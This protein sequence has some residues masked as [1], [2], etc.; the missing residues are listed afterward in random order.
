LG[1]DKHGQA[2]E[3]AHI[4]FIWLP[5]YS[6]DYNPQEHVWKVAKQAVK[7]SITASFDELKDIFEQAISG[8]TFDYTIQR[9]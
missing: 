8:K 2:K 7:N 9:I 4:R 3:F 1:Q 5:P 6:P